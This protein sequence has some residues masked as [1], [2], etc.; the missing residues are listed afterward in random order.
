MRTREMFKLL[1]ITRRIRSSIVHGYVEK[2]D[3]H[4]LFIHKP[5]LKFKETK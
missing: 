4:S 3:K 1:I 2:I 5:T